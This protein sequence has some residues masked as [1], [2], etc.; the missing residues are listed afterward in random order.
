MAEDRYSDL[1]VSA[2]DGLRLYARDYA[3]DI[4]ALPVVC[5]PGLARTSADFHDL[6]AALAHDARKPRRVL[7]LDYR[8]RGRSEYDPEWSHYDVRIE[9]GDV[10]Q[11]LIV[12]GVER[13]VFVGTSRG[14]LIAMALSAARPTL[15]AGVVLN[16]I[17][18]VIET[19][20]LA[21]IRSYV[22]KLPPPSDYAEAVEILKRLSGA[23]FPHLS[24]EEWRGLAQ[25]G[26]RESD[27]RLV[28]NYDPA[29]MKTLE[30]LD[31]EAP[32]PPLWTLF[33][34]LT[35]VP[36]LALRGSNSDILSAVTLG[37]MQ[38]AHPAL[39]A[40][41]VPDQGHAPLLRGPDLIE[42]IRSFVARC[43][44]MRSTRWVDG[45]VLEMNGGF[46][47]EPAPEEAA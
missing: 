9:L 12:A 30:A 38:R 43:E 10:L 18:P 14:G 5:L 4:D 31:L 2:S 19:R 32:V 21:R 22:G 13:A 7:A 40:V 36:V 29:L 23:Q 33:Q 47:P 28:S 8:G 42:R 46:R 27:G 17:G 45:V 35:A 6:A 15:V 26:W 37:A 25:G 20:G 44:E 11:V 34:G 24:D 41:T 16:D 1:L 3:G 39:Q